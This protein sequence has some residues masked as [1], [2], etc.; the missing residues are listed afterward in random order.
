[1]YLWWMKILIL[2]TVMMVSMNVS[3]KP[4]KLFCAYRN[5]KIVVPIAERHS[6]YD[7]NRHCSVSCMLAIRCNDTEVLIAG[8]LKEFQDV[9]GPGDADEGDIVANKYGISIVRNNRADNDR[10]CLEQC[11]LRYR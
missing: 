1:M 8:Y 11:D 3:A 5:A 7:K 2:M 4:K 9:F 6:T 10:E